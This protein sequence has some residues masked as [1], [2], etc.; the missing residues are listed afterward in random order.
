MASHTTDSLMARVRTVLE[1][2]PVSLTRAR[3]AFS[4]DAQPNSV[5]TNSYWLED[6]GNVSSQSVSN[7]TAVRIDRLTVYVA[8]KLNFASVEMLEDVE[9]TLTAIE[10]ALVADGPAQSYSVTPQPIRRI[11]RAAG[12]DVAIGSIALG[13]DYDYAE[14]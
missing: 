13:F 11:T 1:A 14:V 12:A 8:Q 5:T 6:G 9:Q 3:D 4:H 10:R 2:S 7:Y